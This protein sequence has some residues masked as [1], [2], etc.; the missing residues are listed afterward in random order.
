[1]PNLTQGNQITNAMTFANTVLDL[2][3]GCAKLAC[4]SNKL[5]FIAWW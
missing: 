3:L 5:I 4:F 1:M 2:A